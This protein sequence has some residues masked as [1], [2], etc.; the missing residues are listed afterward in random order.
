MICGRHTQTRNR[1][2]QIS[3]IRSWSAGVITAIAAT[4]VNLPRVF[5]MPLPFIFWTCAVRLII[6]IDLLY[7]YRLNRNGWVVL[8]L[9]REKRA[10]PELWSRAF[11]SERRRLCRKTPC[12][13]LRRQQVRCRHSRMMKVQ[14]MLVMIATFFTERGL[15]EVDPWLADRRPHC[16]TFSANLEPRR[17]TTR[18]LSYHLHSPSRAMLCAQDANSRTRMTPSSSTCTST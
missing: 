16:W 3:E 17:L 12:L 18:Q 13:S 10:G 2:R 1:S 7:I 14:A 15:G 9:E 4:G 8:L 11:F 5:K 6:L